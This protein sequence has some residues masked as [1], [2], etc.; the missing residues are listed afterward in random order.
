MK[1]CCCTL[2]YT[3]PKACENCSNNTEDFTVLDFNSKMPVGIFEIE[4]V[5]IQEPVKKSLTQL[6]LDEF[7]KLIEE[8]LINGNEIKYTPGSEEDLINRGE[9]KGNSKDNR[10]NNLRIVC[11]NCNAT[12]PT[13]CGKNINMKK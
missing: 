2:L 8:N 4:P 6:E 9:I 7:K 10:L 13:H 3:N 12:L 1:T 5:K 11:P